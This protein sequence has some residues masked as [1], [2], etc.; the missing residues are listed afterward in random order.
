MSEDEM[1]R[2]LLR[3]S[4]DGTDFHGWQLQPKVRTVEGELNKAL[5]L[6]TGEEIT[7]IGASRTDAGVHAKGNAAVFDTS[8]AIP[9]ERFGHALLPFLPE[10]MSV[11]G[12]CEVDAN[13]HPRKCD[14]LKIYEYRLYSTPLPDPL[15]QR[16]AWHYPR[17]LDG[18]AMRRSAACLV[19]EHDFVSFCSVHTQ[20]E[21]TVR[22]ITDIEIRNEENEWIFIV[23]GNGFL[24]NMI[25][26][27]VGTLTEVGIHSHSPEWVFEVLN[28]K[29]RTFAGPTAP[30]QGLCLKE[31]RFSTVR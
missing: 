22:T 13:F 15:R 12:S 8:S 27:I 5:R 17:A 11:T 4:Y 28:K 30:P 9:P 6:L 7:V 1:K 29:D 20:A 25:R 18:D 14:C 2:I 3:V 23:K 10:D 16:Y 26:I 24:Y 21:S 19:G 31:I